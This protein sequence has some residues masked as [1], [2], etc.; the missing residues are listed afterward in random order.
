M[1]F[2]KVDS[3]GTILS[4]SSSHFFSNNVSYAI[5]WFKVSQRR[6]N[7]SLVERKVPQVNRPLTWRVDCALFNFLTWEEV[8]VRKRRR[9][10]VEDHLPWHQVNKEEL[11]LK[12][13][14]LL[15][16][17]RNQGKIMD[18]IWSV[19][20]ASPRRVDGTM[21]VT[22]QMT[23]LQKETFVVLYPLYIYFKP[24]EGTVIRVL[25]KI[26]KE[27]REKISRQ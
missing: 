7:C 9:Q 23:A 6:K 2:S 19:S 15:S 13:K 16:H 4:F 14:F 25:Q 5:I 24:Q 22:S 20:Q 26:L 27:K 12:E 3:F 11:A 21:S 10:A 17:P 18:H 8:R 1:S